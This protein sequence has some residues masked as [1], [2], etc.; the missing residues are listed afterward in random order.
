MPGRDFV[1]ALIDHGRAWPDYPLD[2]QVREDVREP[3]QDHVGARGAQLADHPVELG[4]QTGRV[5]LAAQHVVT[6]R[7]EA[8]QIRPHGQRGRELFGDHLIEEPAADGEVRIP[9]TGS[10]VDREPGSDQIGP[11]AVRAVRI[12]VV[13]A[14]GE[15]VTHR[16]EAAPHTTAS[17]AALCSFP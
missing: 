6:A 17:L 12:R 3:E 14:L 13:Q 1:G 9:E 8:H 10:D 15:A 5:G 16:H 2:G 4:N 7:G 11:A